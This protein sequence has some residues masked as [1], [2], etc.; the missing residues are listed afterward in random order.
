MIQKCIHFPPIIVLCVDKITATAT[1]LPKA[2]KTTK[3]FN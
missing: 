2:S 3:D 1:P